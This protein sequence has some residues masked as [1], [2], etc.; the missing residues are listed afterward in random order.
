MTKPKTDSKVEQI[1]ISKLKNPN[2]VVRN[3]LTIES[4][5]DLRDSIKRHGII[6]PLVVRQAGSHFEIIAG[7]RRAFAA[8]LAGLQSVP[9]IIRK[10]EGI[11]AEMIKLEENI[12]RKDI[13]PIE[14]SN[15]LQEL[16]T[17]Y[18]MT[19]EEIAEKTDRSIAHI[20]ERL[21]VLKWPPEIKDALAQG[22]I[23]YSV[24]REL[25]K[26]DSD[27]TRKNYLGYAIDSGISPAI[28]SQWVRE[29]KSNKGAIEMNEEGKPIEN[30]SQP[31]AKIIH[32]CPICRGD[33]ESKDSVLAYCH[34]NC[35]KKIEQT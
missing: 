22:L 15:F 34:P 31:E 35:L 16:L 27:L 21:G 7:H 12:K 3:E 29:Y 33:I 6:E 19:A 20:Y 30:L 2:I 28:A 4:V 17:K 10:E 13:N 14:E 18:K 5:E 32:T 8:D 26:I 11:D 24:A 25:A 1:P 9:C 23:T